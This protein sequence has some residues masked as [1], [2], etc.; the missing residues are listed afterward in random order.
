MQT[1]HGTT[2]I[3]LR[4]RALHEHNAFF[5]TRTQY[6]VV[7]R[8]LTTRHGVL[9]RR[10]RSDADVYGTD[11][12]ILSYTVQYHDRTTR[13]TRDGRITINIIHY[14]DGIGNERVTLHADTIAGEPLRLD[15]PYDQPDLVFKRLT[16]LSIADF[17]RAYERIRATRNARLGF[18]PEDLDRCIYGHA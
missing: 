13:G 12:L 10:T 1:P 9:G 17:M 8:T 16:C 3:T 15:R 4:T 7:S 5:R 11:E 14:S 2:P 6:V 18:D